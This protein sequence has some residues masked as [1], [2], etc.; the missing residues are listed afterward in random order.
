M[1][2]AGDTLFEHYLKS[3]SFPG[4]MRR[5]QDTVRAKAGAERHPVKRPARWAQEPAAFPGRPLLKQMGF[6]ANCTW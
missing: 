5:R 2:D 1:F 4:L 6:P 3:V